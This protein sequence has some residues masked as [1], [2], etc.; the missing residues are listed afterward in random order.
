MTAGVFFLLAFGVRQM[1][2]SLGQ[3]RERRREGAVVGVRVV[4]F[5]FV[6]RRAGVGEEVGRVATWFGRQDRH[7]AGVWGGGSLGGLPIQGLHD[8]VVL[9]R[10]V[11]AG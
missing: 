9:R 8:V 10:L 3:G 7:G 11:N 6:P 4:V 2:G 1:P 5:R